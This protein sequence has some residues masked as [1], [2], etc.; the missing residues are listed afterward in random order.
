MKCLDHNLDCSIH[1]SLKSGEP[2]RSWKIVQTARAV[3]PELDLLTATPFMADA[4]EGYEHRRTAGFNERHSAKDSEELAKGAKIY[5]FRHK[6]R[7]E[8]VVDEESV[9]KRPKVA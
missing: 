4:F 2:Y 8:E 6:R 9:R 7:Q 5:V 3:C 1:V